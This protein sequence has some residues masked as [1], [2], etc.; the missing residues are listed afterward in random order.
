[1]SCIVLIVD[2]FPSGSHPVVPLCEA[3][4][5]ELVKSRLS[6][7]VGTHFGMRAA[8][9]HTIVLGFPDCEASEFSLLC[10]KKRTPSGAPKLLV[11]RVI[12]F[13]APVILSRALFTVSFVS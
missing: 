6:W 13:Q 8:N 10:S 3:F 2:N 11:H 5:S 4:L 7:C 1:M 12:S 9:S